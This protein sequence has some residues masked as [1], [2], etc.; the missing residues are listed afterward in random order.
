MVCL[1]VCVP[2]YCAA[3]VLVRL[4]VVEICADENPV[5]RLS[6]RPKM[7][8]RVRAASFTVYSFLGGFCYFMGA[9]SMSS[10][11]AHRSFG[12]TGSRVG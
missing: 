12:E 10:E 4:A 7:A 9:Q 5:W 8:A 11:D 3:L 1:P 2:A 6:R